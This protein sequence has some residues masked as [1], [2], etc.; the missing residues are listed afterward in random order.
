MFHLS[1]FPVVLVNSCRGVLEISPLPWREVNESDGDDIDLVWL[2][3][4]PINVV[5]FQPGP[6]DAA[7]RAAFEQ[8]VSDIQV[9]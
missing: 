8:R 4:H 7:W 2:P 3:T 5:F 9:C 1:G 6:Q